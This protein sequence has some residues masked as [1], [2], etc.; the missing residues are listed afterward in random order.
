MKFLPGRNAGRSRWLAVVAGAAGAVMSMGVIPAEAQ[1]NSESGVSQ[2]AP[3]VW[4]S[5]ELNFHYFGSTTYY[6]CSGLEDRLE[7]ILREMGANQDVQVSASG[8]F[9]S[10]DIGNML[11]A[12]IRVRMPVAPGESQ[13]ETFRAA[14]TPVTLR[15]GSNGSTG[16]GDCELLEQVRDQILPALKIQLVKDELRCIPGHANY[17]GRVL[18]VMALLPEAPA[19]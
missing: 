8:C 18:Q 4:Q 5:Y 14:S 12:R 3:A 17:S 19:K 11:S 7:Q 2:G 9:G 1:P 15:S 6:S 16:S 10:A 13:T